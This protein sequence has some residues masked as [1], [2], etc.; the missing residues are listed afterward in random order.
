MAT[1]RLLF[2]LPTTLPKLD[3]IAAGHFSLSWLQLLQ[4][5]FICELSIMGGASLGPEAGLAM[6]A[7][8]ISSVLGKKLRLS[9]KDAAN[10][11]LS[12]MSGSL[13]GLFSSPLLS[14]IFLLEL[15][16]ASRK[17]QVANLL[18]LLLPA[19][20]SF[21]IFFPI[22][23]TPFFNTFATPSYEFRSWQ[24]AAA[25]LLGLLSALV[26]LV[27]G[28]VNALTKVGVSAISGYINKGA[29]AA[30]GTEGGPTVRSDSSSSNSST[31][32]WLL[33]KKVVRIYI[34]QVIL[35]ALAG[36]VVGLF[37]VL[38]PLTSGSGSIS[39]NQLVK[40]HEELGTGTLVASLF[41]KMLVTGIS[42]HSSFVGGLIFPLL[43][44]GGLTGV[45]IQR[46]LPVL[47][48]GLCFAC[49]MGA[50][51]GALIPLPL[52]AVALVGFSANIDAVQS[53]CVAV[54]VLT[55][56]VAFSGIALGL[57]ALKSTVGQ[58]RGGMQAQ[59]R[60]VGSGS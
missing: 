57:A 48:L 53:S 20:L 43:F 9:K 60:E 52:S 36:A 6:I 58:K 24:L 15:S 49:A 16:G 34:G 39:L 50:V 4:G 10:V 44:L 41:A 17:N 35:T 51:P 30:G 32:P 11:T 27:M 40:H 38:L 54:A 59:E 21:A 13:G 42:V 47:P 19:T 2:K 1:L 33:Q 26:A 23:G 12:S 18:C 37:A 8:G 28:V 25:V 55:A 22:I 46:M 5:A 29:A 56:N 3:E 14:A 7:A 45:L 31:K